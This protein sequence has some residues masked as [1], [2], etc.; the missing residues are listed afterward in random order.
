MWSTDAQ[1]AFRLLSGTA[2]V[3]DAL[4]RRRRRPPSPFGD[5]IA[6]N[7]RLGQYLHV[8]A[9]ATSD[10][11]EMTLYSQRRDATGAAIGTPNV[12]YRTTAFV[13]VRVFD[14][15]YN[16]RTRQY[17]LAWS[18]TDDAPVSL[19][20]NLLDESGRTVSDAAYL[21]GGTVPAAGI[22]ARPPGRLPRGV[23]R[24]GL[25]RRGRP[26]H[27]PLAGRDRCRRPQRS[28]ADRLRAPQ[29][30]RPRRRTTSPPSPW[31]PRRTRAS[32]CG[33]TS[34]RSSG[35][36]STPSGAPTGQDL[37]LSRMGPPADPAWL[38]RS[39][40][41]AYSPGAKQYLVVWQSGPDREPYPAGEVVYGPAP[42]PH[43]RPDRGQRLRHRDARPRGR[44]DGR[45]PGRR[46]GLPRR[47]E[48]PPRRALRPGRGGSPPPV[49]GRPPVLPEDDPTP[50]APP[51]S[52]PGP[53][54][55]A[56]TGP[57]ASGTYRPGRHAARRLGADPGAACRRRRPPG[58][59][60]AGRPRGG[61]DPPARARALRAAG[62]GPVRVRVPGDR[63]ADD[64]P[65]RRPPARHGPDARADGDRRPGGALRDGPA[66]PAR[67]RAPAAA[68]AHPAAGHP[69]GRR[70]GAR[71][72]P[73]RPA[74]DGA[75]RPLADRAELARVAPREAD[76]AGLGRRGALRARLVGDR[77]GDRRA[78]SRLKTDGMM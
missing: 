72:G 40:D 59:A 23:E 71:R 76:R 44:A 46:I 35:A 51:R 42:R 43:G 16:P 3:G 65:R 30:R 61:G 12:L 6:A 18:V 68:A 41:I 15:A 69:V 39:P 17:L 24:A 31:T 53:S 49:A 1:P 10:P 21:T 27:D 5:R 60:R 28:R 38:T 67:R 50:D 2:P 70:P 34:T 55:P 8:W 75:A 13:G 78:T 4:G 11:Y 37:W 64:L 45:R 20:T 63:D 62:V 19:S 32:S 47:V 22:V 33:R 56:I 7:P 52:P 57:G 73:A 36:A 9:A 26:A 29:P 58:P 48:Q 77:V 14:V 54:G 25:A 74:P 66:A